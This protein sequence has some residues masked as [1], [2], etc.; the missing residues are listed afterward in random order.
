MTCP[1]SRI[2]SFENHVVGPIK[3]ENTEYYKIYKN[4]MNNPSVFIKTEPV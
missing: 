2:Y 3:Y 4:F 1:D